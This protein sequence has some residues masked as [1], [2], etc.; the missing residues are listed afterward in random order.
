MSKGVWGCQ[1]ESEGVGGGP[2]KGGCL[3][4]FSLKFPSILESQK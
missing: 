1:G 3:V 4:V 2:K